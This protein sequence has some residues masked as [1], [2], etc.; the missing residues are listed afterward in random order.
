[1]EDKY[2]EQQKCNIMLSIMQ[3]IKTNSFT[4]KRVTKGY[5]QNGDKNDE[6]ITGP[7]SSVLCLQ[8]GA[9]KSAVDKT[10]NKA[11]LNDPHDTSSCKQLCKNCIPAFYLRL[12]QDT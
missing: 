4:P 1:L 6:F 3:N 5:L 12:A 2:K 9:V 7:D 8:P 10:S 11:R